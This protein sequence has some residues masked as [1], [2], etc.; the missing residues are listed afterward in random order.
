M[1]PMLTRYEVKLARFRAETAAQ[2]VTVASFNKRSRKPMWEL[3]LI[4]KELGKAREAEWWN[5]HRRSYYQI[6]PLVLWDYQKNGILLSRPA[7][8]ATGIGS[9]LGADDKLCHCLDCQSRSM[10]RI[11]HAISRLVVEHARG[12]KYGWDS[13]A[14][15]AI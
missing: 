8:T 14:G 9:V 15:R 12:L 2:R 10:D 11:L 13:L 5:L 7:T 3:R 6:E 4:R 1:K